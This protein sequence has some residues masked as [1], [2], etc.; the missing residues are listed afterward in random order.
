MDQSVSATT[1]PASRLGRKLAVSLLLLIALVSAAG[2]A[3]FGLA[4]GAGRIAGIVTVLGSHV[5]ANYPLA[6]GVFAALAFLLQLFILPT[7]T[8]TMLTGGFLF[9]APIAAGLYY[10]G[11]LLAAP[12]VYGA[13][14][15]G[16]GDFADEKLERLLAKYLPGRFK[17][18]LDI[19]RAEGFLAS[20][21]LRLAPVITSAVVPIMAA[22]A[23]IKLRMLMLG[24]LA[25]SWIRPLFWASVGA[26]ARSLSE[27]TNPREFLAQVDLKPL[28]YMF[29]AAVVQFLA[30][31]AMKAR[32]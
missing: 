26:T 30:R 6:L 25:A 15:M 2:I 7:G 27:V 14:R 10:F 20:V 11:Q 1:E 5:D 3:W 32:A 23:G 12:V 22:T 16:F 4:G 8:I 28:L 21:A 31:I 24:S 13:V 18:I 9:G 17:G 29:M 19:A